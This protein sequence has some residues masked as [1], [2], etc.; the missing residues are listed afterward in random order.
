[1]HDQLE[2]I[3]L[4]NIAVSPVAGAIDEDFVDTLAESIIAVGLI[5]PLI[6]RKLSAGQY[7]MIDGHMRAIALRRIGHTSAQVIIKNVSAT[8]AVEATAAAGFIRNCRCADFEA[9]KMLSRLEATGSF[10]TN[11]GLASAIGRRSNELSALRAFG[12]IPHPVLELCGK[13]VTLVSAHLAE[14]LLDAGF[15]LNHP[16]LVVTAIQLLNAGK[17]KNQADVMIWLTKKTDKRIH[18]EVLAQLLP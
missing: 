13:R 2:I 6:V 10:K 12:K 15:S 14:S 16:D 8:G 7:E 11:R 5:S 17:L 9:W 3:L 18:V 4:E 1:M